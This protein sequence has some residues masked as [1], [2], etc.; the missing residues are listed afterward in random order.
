M[1]VES[2]WE[3]DEHAVDDDDARSVAV[4]NEV[5][6][7]ARRGIEKAFNVHPAAPG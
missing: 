2:G 4:E 3:V 5:A 6:V 7:A 1:N